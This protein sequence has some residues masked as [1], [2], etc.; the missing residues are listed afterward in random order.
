M[1]FESPVQERV[2]R[3]VLRWMTELFGTSAVGAP[4]EAP[5]VF[6]RRGQAVAAA[7][8]DAW[9][10]DEATITFRSYVVSGA[11]MTPELMQFLLRQN[12]SFRFGG[13]GVDDGGDIFF[14]HT[15]LGSGCDQQEV[16]ASALAVVT[17]AD[18]FDDR[19]VARWGG[20]RAIEKA[21]GGS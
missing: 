1:R 16:M 7:S 9:G 5:I 2:Y 14:G 12:D 13:F 11:Q 4:P 18:E 3:D 10:D 8:V 17:T 21:L 6:L 15:I 19:I 20:Q